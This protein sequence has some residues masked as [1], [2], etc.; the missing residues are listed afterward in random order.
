M[1]M[2]HCEPNGS[3]S[4]AFDSFELSLLAGSLNHP[5]L[6]EESLAHY[7]W[8]VTM[9][10]MFHAAGLAAILMADA[11]DGEITTDHYIAHGI[12]EVRKEMA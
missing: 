8:R 3:I 10:G 7:Q 6:A 9:A 2:T 12:E 5:G 1:T 4:I 11:K